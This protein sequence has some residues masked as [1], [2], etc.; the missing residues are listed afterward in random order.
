MCETL[1]T[2]MYSTTRAITDRHSHRASAMLRGMRHFPAR[3]SLDSLE[4]SRVANSQHNGPAID[5]RALE[6]CSQDCG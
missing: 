5:C 6:Y 4:A 3:L 2:A 1:V